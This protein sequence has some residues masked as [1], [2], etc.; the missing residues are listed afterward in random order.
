LSTA[1]VAAVAPAAGML[2]AWGQAAC[3]VNL[4]A[5]LV[6]KDLVPAGPKASTAGAA[7]LAALGALGT[8]AV[9]APERST[10]SSR[11]YAGTLLWAFA[12]VMIGQ[13]RRSRS[14]VTTAAGA[15]LTMLAVAAGKR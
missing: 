13:R 12:G 6:A 7:L 11:F 9:A 4:A 5:V 15:A 2:A 14:A 3:G 10:V 8:S 1:E